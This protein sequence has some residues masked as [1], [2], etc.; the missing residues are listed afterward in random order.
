MLDHHIHGNSRRSW[1]LNWFSQWTSSTTNTIDSSQE[2][3]QSSPS[4][5]VSQPTSSASSIEN[6]KQPAISITTHVPGKGQQRD[7]VCFEEDIDDDDQFSSKSAHRRDSKER[8]ILGDLW[9]R[10][11][12]H[13]PHYPRFHWPHHH[14]KKHHLHKNKNNS[15]TMLP[16]SLSRLSIASSRRR[17]SSQNED[18]LTI[19]DAHR[20]SSS[21]QEHSYIAAPTTRP[22]SVYSQ[23]LT[24]RPVSIYSQ[25]FDDNDE[26]DHIQWSDAEPPWAISPELVKMVMDNEYVFKSK[27]YTKA[28]TIFDHSLFCSPLHDIGVEKHV[29]HVG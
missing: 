1:I 5:V 26:D 3:R 23:P 28:H 19:D 9:S 17:S 11:R 16:H 27:H 4:D 21:F 14:H 7:S 29:L 22:I 12:R 10:A 20:L 6:V 8:S 18:S 13:Y 2:Q 15:E 24:S 25:A